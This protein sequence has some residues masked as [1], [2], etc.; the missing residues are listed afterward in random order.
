MPLTV[1]PYPPSRTSAK[2]PGL[3]QLGQGRQEFRTGCRS[4]SARRVTVQILDGS[5]SAVWCGI[6]PGDAPGGTHAQLTDQIGSW[7]VTET[8][9]SRLCLQGPA[10][11][12][13]PEDNPRIRIHIRALAGETALG[14]WSGSCDS[15]ASGHRRLGGHSC[16]GPALRRRPL[17]EPGLFRCKLR[18]AFFPH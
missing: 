13:L 15:G 6:R 3:V 5:P 9:A 4:L 10:R 16:L 1:Q 8:P 7:P 18:G 11:A 2:S 14:E 12:H 17:G